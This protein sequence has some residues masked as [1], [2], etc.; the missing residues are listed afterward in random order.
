MTSSDARLER[1]NGEAGPSR[2]L[3]RCSA[4]RQTLEQACVRQ[5]PSRLPWVSL[6]EDRREEAVLDEER[7]GSGDPPDRLLARAR[8]SAALFFV[9]EVPP[10]ETPSS[11]SSATAWGTASCDGCTSGIPFALLPSKMARIASTVFADTLLTAVRSRAVLPL[12][13]FACGA[14]PAATRIC[15]TSAWPLKAA[16]CSGVSLSRPMS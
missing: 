1:L 4:T 8:A 13:F 15:T 12:A 16:M 11:C 9:G 5:S 10:G 6:S 14:A 3:Q 7:I 2:D